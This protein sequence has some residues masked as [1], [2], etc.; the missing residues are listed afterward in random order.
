MKR[1]DFVRSSFF[2]AASLSSARLLYAAVEGAATRADIPA[3]TGDGRDIVLRGKDI[4]DL[5]ARLRGRVLLAQDPGYEQARRILNPSFDKHPALIVQPT[6]AADV[7]A[8]VSFARANSLLV[9]VK[10]GGHSHSGQST[11]DR[12]MQIDL[13]GLRG[14]RV[15]PRARRAWVEGGTLLGHVDHESVPHGLVTPLGTVSH[16]GVGGLTTGGGFGRLARK[17]GLAADNVVSMDVV[18]ADGA[19]RHASAKENADLF[20][21]LRGGGGNFGVVT[22]FEFALH[23]MQREVIAGAV[24]FPIAKAPEILALYADYAPQA[25]DEL[26]FDP[27]VVL[28]PGGAPG[29]AGV[30][31]TWC[32][33]ETEAERALAPIRALGTP[34]KDGIGKKDYRDVQRANDDDDPRVGSY[35]KGGFIREMSRELITAAIDGLQGHPA[36]MTVFFFQHCS[37]AISRIPNRATAFAHRDA[38]ANMM[39][40]V[41]WPIGQD[42]SEHVRWIKQYWET[43][44]SFTRGFY[45]N[46]L[47]LE[48]P[49]MKVYANYR[50]NYERLVAVKTK[51]DPTNLLRLNANVQPRG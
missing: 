16:T 34:L 14:V 46:D 38:L 32:G 8:A 43:L 35:I 41:A 6:G 20:W 23:P 22:S 2:A 37:G 26:Y 25:T 39:V 12:G 19:L 29:M 44:D 4:A 28:P 21:G 33:K 30:S 27:F 3:V 49:A 5:A 11:C 24:M 18:T 36:R 42:P 10:C 48:T 50:E 15:D 7:Q 31:L 47:P 17:Y 1:R 51:Y 45:V 13:A 40:N 9:A